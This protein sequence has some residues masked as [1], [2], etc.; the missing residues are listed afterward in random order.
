MKIP[1]FTIDAF[2]PGAFGGNPA[3]VCLLKEDIPD[4]LKQKI[5]MEMNLSET[6][7]ILPLD[8]TSSL[9]NPFQDGKDFELRW[10]TPTTEVPLCGHATL[11]S[12]ATLFYTQN[13]K[14]VNTIFRSAFRTLLFHIAKST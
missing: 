8:G 7:F 11:A 13:N 6:A 2:S 5:A 3:A 1:I 10:F 12:A 4:D 9:A 14:K